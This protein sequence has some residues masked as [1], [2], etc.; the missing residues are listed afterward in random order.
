MHTST[1][2]PEQNMMKHKQTQDLKSRIECLTFQNAKA[3][4]TEHMWNVQMFI[5][6]VFNVVAY[7][8]DLLLF[9]ILVPHVHN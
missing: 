2:I 6:G 4:S 1:S 7:T 5:I 9:G 3:V 8:S